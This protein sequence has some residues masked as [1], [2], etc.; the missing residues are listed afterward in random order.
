MMNNLRTSASTI[1]TPGNPKPAR[2]SLGEVRTIG[3]LSFR[4]RLL[5]AQLSRL[6]EHSQIREKRWV[7]DRI[8]KRDP[9][10][11]AGKTLNG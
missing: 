4:L 8:A 10:Y 9:G 11:L 6:E 5:L 7:S 2:P 3:S 1:H